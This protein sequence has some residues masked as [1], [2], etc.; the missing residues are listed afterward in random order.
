MARIRA[1]KP[2]FFSSETIAKLSRDAR[3]TFIGLWT[4]ADDY[5]RLP[6][7]PRVLKGHLWA[8]DDDVTSVDVS[9]HIQQMI[10]HA[11]VERYEVDGRRYLRIRSW[12]E[13]QKMNR[14]A[15]AKHPAPPSAGTPEGGRTADAVPTQCADTAEAVGERKGKE[16]KGTSLPRSETEAGLSTGVDDDDP[17]A[18][19]TDPTEALA[20]RAALELGRRD[21]R[22]SPSYVGAPGPHVR[23]CAE[24]RWLVDGPELLALARQHPDLDPAALADLLP[25]PGQ[26][27]AQA[28]HPAGSATPT[29]T[30]PCPHCARS[31]PHVLAC[32]TLLAG[33]DRADAE[34][35]D[36]QLDAELDEGGEQ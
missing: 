12:E 33:D 28:L 14:K 8:L 16:G 29:R 15:G 5:G 20:R 26:A 7:N 11:L 17:D 21:S 24:T 25:Q 22:R 4:E 32:P 1:I 18:A 2:E 36:A 10:D 13:H 23:T 27:T 3:L 31:R 6:D 9:L 19:P 30:G 34:R 35:L